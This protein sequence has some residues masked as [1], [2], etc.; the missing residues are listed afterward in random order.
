MRFELAIN[1]RLTGEA[2]SNMIGRSDFQ[3]HT[4]SDKSNE[5]NY[6]FAGKMEL[7]VA[8]EAISPLIS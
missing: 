1:C 4:I 2:A 6:V 5:F 7:P 3:M 8:K